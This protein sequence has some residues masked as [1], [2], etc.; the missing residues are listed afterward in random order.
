[1]SA[2]IHT[3]EW[4]RIP[5]QMIWLKGWM[6]WYDFC[7]DDPF[8]TFKLNSFELIE[9]EYQ[10]CYLM[11]FWMMIMIYFVWRWQEESCITMINMRCLFVCFHLLLYQYGKYIN[12]ESFVSNDSDHFSILVQYNWLFFPQSSYDNLL[13]LVFYQ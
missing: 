11:T 1:M 4:W 6:G 13:Y 7:L 2:W 3:H 8:L 5:M 10:C 9:K 12:E